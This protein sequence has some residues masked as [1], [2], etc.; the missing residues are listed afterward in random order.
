M[1]SVSES[2]FTVM[3]MRFWHESPTAPSSGATRR[4]RRPP[5]ALDVL[6]GDVDR[7]GEGWPVPASG[8]WTVLVAAMQP[9][10]QLTATLGLGRVAAGVGPAVSLG[11]VET[12]HLPLVW[13]RY[14]QVRWCR[15][16]SSSQVSRHRCERQAPPVSDRIRS[17][18]TPRAV[19]QPTARTST[20]VA[21]RVVSSS[22]M[23]PGFFASTWSVAPGWSCSSRPTGRRWRGVSAAFA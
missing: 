10:V 20:A 9:P 15:V 11:A 17:T 22:G 23:L 6:L 7:S 16:P 14:G 19:N 4:C 8:V 18:A 3:V 5:S 21:A 1:S 2:P 13:G 12:L